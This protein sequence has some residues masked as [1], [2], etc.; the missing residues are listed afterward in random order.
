LDTR[1]K[2]GN[3]GIGQTGCSTTAPNNQGCTT[4]SLF[5]PFVNQVYQ[6]PRTIGVQANYRF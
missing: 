4:Y 2:I 1:E 3:A 5:N 6:K